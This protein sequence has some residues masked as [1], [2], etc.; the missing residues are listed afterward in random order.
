MEDAP[1][2]FYSLVDDV[3][4]HEVEPSAEALLVDMNVL[5]YHQTQHS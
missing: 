4:N 2:A 5:V 1:D 3:G